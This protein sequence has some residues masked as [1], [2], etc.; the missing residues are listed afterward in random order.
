M[1]DNNNGKKPRFTGFI[2]YGVLIILL[3]VLFASMFGNTN[4]KEKIE[5]VYSYIES[6]EYE[7]EDVVVRGTTATIKYKA[8]GKDQTV[9][10][11]IPYEGVDDVIEHL[12]L[13]KKEGKIETYK[14]E[15]PFDWTLISN[16]VLTIAVIASVIL[17]F[18]MMTRQGGDKGVFSFGQSKAKLVTPSKMKVRFKDVAGSAEEKEELSEM[19]DFLKNPKKNKPHCNAAF[20][21]S[22]RKQ[23][24][25]GT[26]VAVTHFLRRF[27]GEV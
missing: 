17:V 8:D 27:N 4:K 10:V 23:D 20:V 11:D 15:E 21:L 3:C 12:E 2:F 1:S 5:Y 24:M 19:V 13:A 25:L 18:A 22:K 9:V 26:D 7:V 6:E 14:Y 16:I